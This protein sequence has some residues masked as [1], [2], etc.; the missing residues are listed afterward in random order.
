MRPG[1]AP[2]RKIEE[3]AIGRDE[4]DAARGELRIA[5]PGERNQIIRQH[6][7]HPRSD[8]H[9]EGIH[10]FE[11]C[12]IELHRADLDDFGKFA[13]PHPTRLHRPFPGGEFEVE[14]H[15]M[16]RVSR[17]HRPIPPHSLTDNMLEFLRLSRRDRQRLEFAH[18]FLSS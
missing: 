3:T 5:D 18:R 8:Q 4:I 1:L 14:D 11:A 13:R 12:R 10:L 16:G 6:R 15:D 9:I 17:L 2:G 7:V